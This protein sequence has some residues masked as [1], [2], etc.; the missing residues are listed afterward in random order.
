VQITLGDLGE[1]SDPYRLRQALRGVDTVVHLAATIRD[2]PPHRIEELNGLA[3]V[4]LLRAAEHAGVRRFVFFSAL[5]ASRVQRTRFFRAKALAEEAVASSPLQTTVFAPSIVYDHSDPWITL[6]RRFSFLPV[7]PV[8]GSG[9]ARYQPIWAHDVARAVGTELEQDGGRD[10]YE[11]A[12]PDVLSYDEMSDLVSRAAGRPRPLV[13][14]PLPLVRSGLIALR[15]VFGESVFA[16]WEEAE[17]MEVGMV[18]PR[19]TADAEELGV[20]PRRMAEV[21]GGA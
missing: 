14:V 2:Q 12:G 16:T 4:R 13:H 15:R 8:A 17:L 10:R 7:L 11:L 5:N 1:L 19:G 6:L 20:Q 21:L 9:Q 3:T 18:T